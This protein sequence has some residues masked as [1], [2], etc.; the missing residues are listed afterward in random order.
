MKKRN[1][2]AYRVGLGVYGSI[3]LRVHVPTSYMCLIRDTLNK[4][5][6]AEALNAYNSVNETRVRTV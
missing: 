5:H 1:V 3:L 6:W 4:R 2:I